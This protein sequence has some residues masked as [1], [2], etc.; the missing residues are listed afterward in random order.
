MTMAGSG[1]ANS[2]RKSNG[3]DAG[4]SATNRSTVAAM[5]GRSPS[6]TRG[7]LAPDRIAKVGVGRRVTKDH[8]S[9][10]QFD[11]FGELVRPFRRQPLERL[12]PVG[13][14]SGVPKAGRDGLVGE[15]QPTPVGVAPLD[16]P[17]GQDRSGES[18]RILVHLARRQVQNRSH[19]NATLVPDPAT[20]AIPAGA[21]VKNRVG[22]R[23]TARGTGSSPAFQSL[24][25]VAILG[26][27]LIASELR[28]PISVRGRR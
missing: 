3:S 6:T 22:H 23:E 17:V 28:V 10:Q 21:A 9:R 14:Q 20:P 24:W 15:D 4:R 25:P 27:T 16:R 5:V 8:P 11:H 1:S 13:R 7:E 2:V 12:D 26:V 19:T 18:G